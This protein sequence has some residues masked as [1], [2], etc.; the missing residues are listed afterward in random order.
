M[1]LCI[2]HLRIPQGDPGLFIFPSSQQAGPRALFPSACPVTRHDMAVLG[3]CI[4]TATCSPW[5]QGDG[6]VS[7]GALHPIYRNLINSPV[8][9]SI[10][11][12][13]IQSARLDHWILWIVNCSMIVKIKCWDLSHSLHL[14]RRMAHLLED[15]QEKIWET[16][17]SETSGLSDHSVVLQEGWLPLKKQEELWLNLTEALLSVVNSFH[18]S[19][20]IETIFRLIRDTECDIIW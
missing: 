6:D 16:F 2:H 15:R 17:L 10:P 19:Q 8:F 11:P 4:S 3:L 12:P 13:T 20:K 14:P 9:S 18:F 7:R 5:C 1:N